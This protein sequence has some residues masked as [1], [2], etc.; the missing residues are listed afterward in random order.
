MLAE[1]GPLGLALLVVALVLPLLAVRRTQNN[2][3]VATAAGAYVTF[4][5]HAGVD[6]DWEMPVVTI[7]GLSCGA[8]ILVGARR[9]RAIALGLPA[10]A[11]LL[12]A[13]AA[14]AVYV[15]I[16]IGAADLLSVVLG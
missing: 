6:W 15:S 11:A 16:R 8:A 13:A 12:A 1:L 5:L 3:L 7:V 4:L 9:G 14:V 2:M 10:R